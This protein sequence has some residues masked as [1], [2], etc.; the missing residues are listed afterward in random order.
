MNMDPDRLSFKLKEFYLLELYQV[1]LYDEQIPSLQEEH[2]VKAYE[3]MVR[4]E[5]GH[6]DYFAERLRE[7][8]LDQPDLTGDLFGIAGSVSAKALGLFSPAERYRLGVILETKASEMYGEFIRMARDEDD[9]LTGM[10]WDYR[11]DEDFH[12]YWF[13]ANL[14]ALTRNT[15]A[16]ANV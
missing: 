9:R 14:E 4:V 5:Q 3:H 13:A 15:P 6:A 11:T 8:G 12:K 2:A 10:L 7:H 16:T 1:K